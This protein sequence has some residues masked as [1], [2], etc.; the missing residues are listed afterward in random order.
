MA[1]HS[2]HPAEINALCEEIKG[3]K[4]I[5]EIG[6]R[7][8]EALLY[9]AGVLSPGAKIVSIELPGSLWGRSDSLPVLE[10]V[11]DQ[12]KDRGFDAKLLLGNSRDQWVIDFA[13]SEGPYDFVFIDGDHTIEGIMA[14]W[15][16]YGHMGRMVGFHD[17]AAIGAKLPTGELLGVPEAWSEIK[18]G[19]KYK[20]F[21]ATPEGMNPMGI[22]L[23]W[24]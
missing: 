9:F 6:S 21:I 2:Q 13:M 17:I 16:N 19:R 3:A 4:S 22:G 15:R 24:E 18:W 7:Y 23:V 14:D 10:Q 5:L 8:G 11:I 12:L 20:E 1:K